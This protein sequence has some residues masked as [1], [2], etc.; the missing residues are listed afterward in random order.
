HGKEACTVRH[1]LT[2]QGGFAG[3]VTPAHPGPWERII[4]DICAYPAEYAPGT[5]AGYH[6]TAGWYVLAEIVRRVDG[7]SIVPFLQQEWFTPLGMADTHLGI[8][9]ERQAAL[10]ERLALVTLGRTEREHFAS[11]A[12]VDQ[13]N[14]PEEMARVNPSGGMRG[15]ARDL[16]RFYECLLAKGIAGERRIV[17]KR[18][19]ELFTA[20]HR[21]GIPD[22]TLAG[23]PLPWGLG[24][25][26]YGNADVELAVS[27]R[28]FGH[29]GMVSSVAFADPVS[30]LVCI[31]ITTGLL[32]PVT[33]AQRLRAING[34]IVKAC[35]P[36]AQ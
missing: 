25:V 34:P 22:K 29:S 9:L 31:V 13:F 3:A 17:D 12:F 18:T 23:A 1:V 33:N 5:R 24:F 21:W 16:G 36:V 7:R 32:D 27:R 28:V 35:R 10:R 11:Q 8:P 2:H 20:C 14:G 6:A 30:G 15:P 26:L 4:A 19:V